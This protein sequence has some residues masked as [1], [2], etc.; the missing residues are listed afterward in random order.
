MTSFEGSCNLARGKGQRPLYSSIVD[1]TSGLLGPRLTQRRHTVALAGA[2]GG[3]RI[4][5]G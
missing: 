2:D 1:G 3:D 4:A 5:V